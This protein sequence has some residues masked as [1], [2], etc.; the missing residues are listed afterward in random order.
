MDGENNVRLSDTNVS[1]G[2]VCS[3]YKSVGSTEDRFLCK[4]SF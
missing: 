1:S 2:E 3:F 4:L